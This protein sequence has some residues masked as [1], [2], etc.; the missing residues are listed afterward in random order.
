MLPVQLQQQ[1]LQKPHNVTST[2]T[3][4]GTPQ[5]LAPP[6]R[7]HRRPRREQPRQ[8]TPSNQQTP[9]EDDLLKSSAISLASAA[10]ASC[11]AAAAASSVAATAPTSPYRS[12]TAAAGGGGGNNRMNSDLLYSQ[13]LNLSQ[14]SL[15]LNQSVFDIHLLGRN[16]SATPSQ[17]ENDQLHPQRSAEERQY[18]NKKKYEDDDTD[19]DD[20]D[21]DEPIISD[22]ATV[23]LTAGSS[24][25]TLTATI[26]P[27]S[28]VAASAATSRQSSTTS[29][30]LGP[31]RTAASSTFPGQLQQSQ[32]YNR[33]IS[34]PPS[35]SLATTTFVENH[36]SPHIQSIGPSSSSTS[37]LPHDYKLCDSCR[38]LRFQSHSPSSG[39]LTPKSNLSN[40]TR[41]L[42]AKRFLSHPPTSALAAVAPAAVA[43]SSVGF[44]ASLLNTSLQ[45]PPQ[46]NAPNHH[47]FNSLRS[48]TPFSRFQ[49]RRQ[50]SSSMSQSGEDL[51]SPSYLSWRKLQ[52]SRAKL[53][54]SSK[55][56]AL[57]SGFAMVSTVYIYFFNC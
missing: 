52:L 53:K 26:I 9:P 15:L 42:N 47:P 11:S 22:D 40:S 8:R 17:L 50:T 13:Q 36:Q 35:H 20:E 45:P 27:A 29:A 57:L 33:S 56:S 21:D 18:H 10:A 31:Q 16:S 54:A 49:P 1:H 44:P 43:L 39:L 32:Y 23:P 5:P 55:T 12:V 48:F 37:F 3:A 51:H 2:T 4:S 19:S 25:T 34:T 6:P 14:S 46:P 30:R 7:E 28:I 24:S 38:P 41:Y